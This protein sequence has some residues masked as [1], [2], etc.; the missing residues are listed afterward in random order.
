MITNQQ[1]KQVL[2]EIKAAQSHINAACSL[3][4]TI[5]QQE[6]IIIDMARVYPSRP[7]S[8]GELALLLGKSTRHLSRWLKPFKTELRK[9]GVSDRAKMLPAEAVY[10][11]CSTLDITFPE[12]M[13]EETDKN[14]HRHENGHETDTV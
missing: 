9:M 7:M 4:V 1:I 10:L 11:I 14:R 5:Q 12:K 8:K 13:T 2:V 6:D 3:L